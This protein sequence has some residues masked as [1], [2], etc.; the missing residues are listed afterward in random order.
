MTQHKPCPLAGWEGQ[1][2]LAA[3]QARRRNT[4]P[5]RCLLLLYVCACIFALL[6]LLECVGGVR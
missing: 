2:K 1:I 3:E 4:V 6:L 5:S